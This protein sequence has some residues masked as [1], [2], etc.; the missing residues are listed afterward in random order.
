MRKRRGLA[1][2]TFLRGALASGA[3]VA[4]GMPLLDAMTNLGGT[5]HAGGE[6]FPLRFALWFWGNG[7]HPG[8]WAPTAVGPGWEPTSLLRGLAPVRTA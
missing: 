3:A 4:L 8:S 2:R 7:T 5:A 6:E 1:R